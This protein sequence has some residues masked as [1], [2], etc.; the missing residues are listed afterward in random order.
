MTM[1]PFENNSAIDQL[2]DSS[3]REFGAAEPRPGLELRVLAALEA[4]RPQMIQ[5]P[6]WLR[7]AWSFAAVA[8]IAL[9][10]WGLVSEKT[11][12]EPVV[13]SRKM[14]E[15]DVYKLIPGIREGNPDADRICPDQPSAAASTEVSRSPSRRRIVREQTTQAKTAA[16]TAPRL[17][18]FPSQQPLS[19]QEL[20]LA[21]LVTQHPSE[22]ILL[23][24]AQEE[25]DAEWQR[26]REPFMSAAPE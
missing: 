3:L 2:L 15:C 17:D 18:S 4:E 9:V 26:Y 23:A 1:E 19:E 14:D 21:R 12:R 7:A 16:I 10:M 24:Q 13:E 22:A 11:I 6:L 5:R 20:L 25:N 8:A